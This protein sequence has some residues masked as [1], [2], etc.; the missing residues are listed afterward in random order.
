MCHL[1]KDLF[2]SFF[3][4]IHCHQGLLCGCNCL[5][6]HIEVFLL[7]VEVRETVLVQIKKTCLSIILVSLLLDNV[8]LSFI[9]ISS[10]SCSC[11]LCFHCSFFVSAFNSATLGV[12]HCA[13]LVSSFSNS[14]YFSKLDELYKLP[15]CILYLRAKHSTYAP[16]LQKIFFSLT[17]EIS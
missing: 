17:V 5:S 14:L 4:C 10:L 16:W 11:G 3:I 7:C 1:L 2:W 6:Q 15:F 9:C 12:L 13:F 8:M